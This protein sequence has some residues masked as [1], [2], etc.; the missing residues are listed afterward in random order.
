MPNNIIFN[1]SALSI[2]DILSGWVKQFYLH[3]IHPPQVDIMFDSFRE[4]DDGSMDD[5]QLCFAVFVHKHSGEPNFV[6]PEHDYAWGYVV[7][8]QF[9]QACYF[10]WIDTEGN[11]T[12]VSEPMTELCP[13]DVEYIICLIE[14]LRLLGQAQ[15]HTRSIAAKN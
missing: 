13:A 5:S 4:R 9:D 6:Y 10:V 3:G 1:I 2:D 7:H 11:S 14:Y 8:Q 15:T 12:A